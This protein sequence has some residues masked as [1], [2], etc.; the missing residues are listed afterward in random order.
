MTSVSGHSLTFGE[1][2]RERGMR[3]VSFYFFFLGSISGR[4]WTRGKLTVFVLSDPVCVCVF[5]FLCRVLV[6]VALSRLQ[7]R[8]RRFTHGLDRLALLHS[9]HHSNFSQLLCPCTQS[10]SIISITLYSFSTH[11]LYRVHYL[12][13]LSLSL[14]LYMYSVHQTDAF[15][16]SMTLSRFRH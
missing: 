5:L 13:P 2:K 14:S 6:V 3:G 12:Y 9:A 10:K 8:K 11:S 16:P 15:E 4:K 7:R 1:G